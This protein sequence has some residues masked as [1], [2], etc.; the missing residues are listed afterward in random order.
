MWRGPSLDI[1]EVAERRLVR[2]L[3]TPGA[4]SLSG[5]WIGERFYLYGQYPEAGRLWQVT[6]DTAELGPGVSV[7][8]SGLSGCSKI[9]ALM[10]MIAARDR[11]FVYEPFGFKIDRLNLCGRS[12][13]G[14]VY[15][16][17]RSSGKVIAHLSPSLYFMRLV[18]CND[19]HQ[20]VGLDARG[21]V[22]LFK[23]DSGTGNILAERI[24]EDDVYNLALANIPESILPRGEVEAISCDRH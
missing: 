6:S 23:L 13:L 8:I 10:T 3:K 17:D 4:E 1:F 12:I 7:T 16:L 2:R 18:A 14:G 19:D 21:P 5:A 11:I 15:A 9:P 20:L 22:R 24:L